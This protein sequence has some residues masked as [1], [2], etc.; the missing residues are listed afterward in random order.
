MSKSN[1]F[2][3]LENVKVHFPVRGG[4]FRKA[5]GA[6]KA[7][8]GVSFSLKEG[9]TLGLVGESGCGKS[10]L[11]K[12]I[13][14]LVKPTSGKITLGSIFLMIA[15]LKKTFANRYR[16]FFKILPNPLILE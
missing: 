6:C 3:C 13:V 8:D 14:R 4:V 7:V 10:T 1:N 5:I 15:K 2:L 16:W 12:T 9:E 11:A